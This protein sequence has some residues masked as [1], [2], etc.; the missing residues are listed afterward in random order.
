LSDQNNVKQRSSGQRIGDRGE[1]FVRAWVEEA[2]G[3]IARAQ[4]KD[5]GV[6]LELEL[7]ERGVRGELIKVQVRAHEK[8]EAEDFV[9]APVERKLLSYAEECRVPIVVVAVDLAKK[10]AFFC[11]LQAWLL[12]ADG[13]RVFSEGIQTHELRIPREKELRHGLGGELRDIARHRTP[14]QLWLGMR[15]VLRSAIALRD[16]RSSEALA[17][18][19]ASA[20]G[21][22]QRPIVELLDQV[23]ALGTRIWATEEGNRVSRVL[24]G[25]CRALGGEFTVDDIKRL[26]VRGDA[27]SRTGINALGVLYD[28]HG[29]HVKSLELPKG[30][31]GDEPR[32]CYYCLLRER[33]LGRPSTA[34]FTA[35]TDFDVDGMTVDPEAREDLVLRWANRGDSAILDYV[36]LPDEPAS[37]H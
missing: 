30:F 25:L 33:Y 29:E 20:R 36:T 37:E 24:F 28:A 15:D 9:T 35:D 2:G 32:I 5:F 31:E 21:Y 19:L 12:T 22:A 18:L 23:L 8:A 6:D 1:A 16:E 13:R 7:D 11:W 14:E 4:E 27:Y 26:V 34:L 3:W 10:E 17:E